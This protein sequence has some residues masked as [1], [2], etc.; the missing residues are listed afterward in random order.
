MYVSLEINNKRGIPVYTEFPCLKIFPST[1]LSKEGL[2]LHTSPYLWYWIV[3]AN[4]DWATNSDYYLC[5]DHNPLGPVAWL[6][7]ISIDSPLVLGYW[8]ALIF[9]Y[10]LAFKTAVHPSPR[11]C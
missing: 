11:I 10:L 3:V 8:L 1:Q 9:I 5:L 7:R 6:G 4:G 2:P